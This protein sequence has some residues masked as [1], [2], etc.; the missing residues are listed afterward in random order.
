MS[1]KSITAITVSLTPVFWVFDEDV[2][3]GFSTIF[4]NF[5]DL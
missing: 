5:P 3:E 4:Y 2:K 1:A